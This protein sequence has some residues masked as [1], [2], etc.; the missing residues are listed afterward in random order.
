MLFYR[1]CHQCGSVHEVR[2]PEPGKCPTC[3]KAL[4]PLAYFHRNRLR[5]LG[6]LSPVNNADL[7]V[8]GLAVFWDHVESD[9]S[10]YKK[11]P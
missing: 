5:K 2:D 7:L 8:R 9:P 6:D 3:Q 1:R 10:G 4:L 11:G